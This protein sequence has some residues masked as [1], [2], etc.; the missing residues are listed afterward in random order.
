MLNKIIEY[1]KNLKNEEGKLPIVV[2]LI[3]LLIFFIIIFK[4][5]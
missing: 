3:F 4:M 1:I 5:K 2:R